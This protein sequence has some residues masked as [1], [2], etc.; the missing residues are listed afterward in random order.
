MKNLSTQQQ[1]PAPRSFD[2]PFRRFLAQLS[3]PSRGEGEP[4]AATP[5]PCVPSSK[6][7]AVPA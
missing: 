2:A 1:T 7:G 5:A 3:G 6:E 4:Y